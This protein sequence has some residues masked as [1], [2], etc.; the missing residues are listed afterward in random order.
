[1]DSVKLRLVLSLVVA[2]PLACGKGEPPGPPSLAVEEH[3]ARATPLVTEGGGPGANSAVY[4]MVRNAG[5]TPDK[6]LGGATAVAAAAELH[7][8]R[9]ED[10]VMRMRRVDGVEIPPGG[11]VV[12]E[13]GGLHLML[14]GLTEP[15]TEGDT[16]TLFLDFELSGRLEILV[17]VRPIGGQ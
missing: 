17:P 9:L 2:L 11:Q 6:L 10:G 15:L 3:W 12:L 16:L 13:P 4:L 7:E 8:S 5:G 14:V 1:M